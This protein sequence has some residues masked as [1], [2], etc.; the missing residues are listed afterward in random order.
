MKK[1]IQ[2]AVV[3]FVCFFTYG[4]VHRVLL[5]KAEET[6]HLERSR[7]QLVLIQQSKQSEKKAT[8]G[9][10]DKGEY[11]FVD[12]SKLS[13]GPSTSSGKLPLMYDRRMS[14]H[15]GRGINILM[16]DGTVEW[17]SNAEWL[18]KFVAEHPHAKLPMP[19]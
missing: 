18:K 17:D 13:D 14:N 19:E 2:I 3:F 16:V 15:A 11:F 5:A 9:T 7:C 4:I 10:T 8:F 6:F 12:W 1:A